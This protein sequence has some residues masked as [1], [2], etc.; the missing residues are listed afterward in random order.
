[1]VTLIVK[2]YNL[3]AIGLS[4]FF[5]SK[6]SDNTMATD[7]KVLPRILNR[8]QTENLNGQKIPVIT[9]EFKILKR[10]NT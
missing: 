4:V 9:S 6:N 8:R 2:G 1:M 10:Y 5:E 3:L 7:T